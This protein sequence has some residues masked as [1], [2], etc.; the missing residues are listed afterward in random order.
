MSFYQKL[1]EVGSKYIAM[2]RLFK[3]GFNLSP[4]YRR[5]T[6]RIV[7]VAPDMLTIK[8]KLPI[9]Y[10]NRNYMG[11]VFGGSMF[12]AV[13]PIPMVQLISLL[14][15]EY[16]VWDKSA[17]IAFRRPAREDLYAEF[18]Y[19]LAELEEIKRAVAAKQETEIVKT[20]LL[21]N[22]EGAVVFCEVRKTIYVADKLFYKRKREV[23]DKKRMEEAT[24]SV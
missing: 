2:H 13:D 15:K 11:S 14:G 9:S 21:T 24:G 7:Y 8:V 16:V 19:T 23:K 17:E 12:S 22:R 5:S 6:A 20:T 18:V 10:K 1:T 3:A 4:M